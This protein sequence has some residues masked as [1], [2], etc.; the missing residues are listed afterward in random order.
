MMLEYGNNKYYT[1]TKKGYKLNTTNTTI[2]ERTWFSDKSRTQLSVLEE[3]S[4]LR[5]EYKGNY[6]GFFGKVVN[7]DWTFEEDGSYSIVLDLI[8]LGDV[9]E[10]LQINT[11]VSY[12]TVDQIKKQKESTLPT[13]GFTEDEYEDFKENDTLVTTAQND[14]I[15]A[16]IFNKI[17]NDNLWLDTN[18]KDWV[19]LKEAAI[20]SSEAGQVSQDIVKRIPPEYSYFISFGKLLYF[21]KDKIIPLIEIKFLKEC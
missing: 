7:F 21:L 6:D 20:D 1:K 8:T 17:S 2:I 18:N 5:E 10:S 11:P 9:I 12:F 16:W 19:N 15:S 3:I 13:V 4:D 14:I